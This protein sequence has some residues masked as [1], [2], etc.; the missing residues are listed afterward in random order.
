VMTP[1]GPVADLYALWQGGALYEPARVK[2]PL[3]FVR[4]EWDSVC[5]DKDA[6][7]FMSELGSSIKRDVKIPKGTH[8][9]HLE[10]SRVQLHQVV[11]QFLQEQSP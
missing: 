4:G 10:E 11:N 1:T 5:N 7:R 2:Q 8:L 3:L 9:M 6:Q